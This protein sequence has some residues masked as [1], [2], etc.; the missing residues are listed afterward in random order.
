MFIVH[1]KIQVQVWQL[2]NNNNNIIIII[3]IIIIV[4]VVIL[5][6]TNL[7]HLKYFWNVFVLWSVTKK[8]QDM[9]ASHQK[10]ITN[11]ITVVAHSL[12]FFCTI[13]SSLVTQ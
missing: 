1:H 5:S 10:H 11:I 9:E 13:G 3:I 8:N 6:N 7:K 2:N 12:V 4:V